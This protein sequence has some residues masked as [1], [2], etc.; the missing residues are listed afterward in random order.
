MIEE[1]T[2]EQTAQLDVYFQEALDIGLSTADVDREKA[3][4]A[5]RLAYEKV[6]IECP[7]TFIFAQSPT[8]CVDKQKQFSDEHKC[9]L[10]RSTLFEHQIY[11]CHDIYWLQFY[12]FFWKE[13]GFDELAIIEGLL[14]VSRTCGWWAPYKEVVFIQERPLEIHF[15][16]GQLHNE[17]G[18]AILYRDG[19]AV[20]ALNGVRVPEWLVTTPIEDITGQQV[21]S[22]TNAQVRAEAIR[23]IGMERLVVISNPIV[24]DKEENYELVDLQAMFETEGPKPY[25]KMKNPS[26]PDLWHVEGVGVECTTIDEALHFRKPDNMRRIPVD[27]ENGKDWFQQG[28]VCIFPKNATSLKPRPKILT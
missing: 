18:P 7:E 13:V 5:V 10:S 19:F 26:V 24:L 12:N 1:L 2:P 4:T 6:D 28:D 21:L 15:N 8:D 11:G 14:E 27:A 22:I 17:D 23:K 20:W 3:I 9:G 25:L 16:E